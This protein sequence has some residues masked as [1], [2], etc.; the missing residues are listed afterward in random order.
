[1][2]DKDKSTGDA[3]SVID[4]TK[5]QVKSDTF[6]QTPEKD[7]DNVKGGRMGRATLNPTSSDGCCGG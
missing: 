6:S 2:A 7:A 4:A 5:P 1:M 3:D